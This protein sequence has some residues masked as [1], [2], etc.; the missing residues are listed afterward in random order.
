M[1]S[2]LTRAPL[3]V[4]LPIVAMAVLFVVALRRHSRDWLHPGRVIIGFYLLMS[5]TSLAFDRDLAPT[6]SMN[7]SW[8]NMAGYTTLLCVTLLPALLIVKPDADHVIHHGLVRPMLLW[9]APLVA[10]S[11]FFLAP[12]ALHSLGQGFA[13]TRYALNVLRIQPLPGGFLTTV[14]VAVASYYIIFALLFFAALVRKMGKLPAIVALI[15]LL[16]PIVHA[17]VFGARDGAIWL[18]HALLFGLWV[19]TGVLTLRMRRA[20]VRT[21]VV[22]G[23]VGLLYISLATRDRFAESGGGYASGTVGYFGS[24]PYVFSETVDRLTTFYGPANRFPLVAALVGGSATERYEP[25]QWSFG[26]FLTDFY[27]V[28][29]WPSAVGLS[30]VLTLLTLG[31]MHVCRKRSAL[32]Y[33]LVVAAYAQFMVQGVFYFRLG[34]RAGNLYHVS[35]GILILVVLVMFPD[36]VLKRATSGAKRLRRAPVSRALREA[37]GGHAQP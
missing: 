17:A 28:A 27:S 3:P 14:S 18:V 8:W 30:L 35:L 2:V 33:T 4:W 20:A 6:F 29:G 31:A 7:V 13:A 32:A 36:H 16:L 1:R 12:F 22:V 26:T 10:F 23:M 15:G 37:A 5:L 19:T 11:L 24:Q 9:S 25:F 21:I 34:N